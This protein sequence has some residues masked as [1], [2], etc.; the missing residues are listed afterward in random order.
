MAK[1][2]KNNNVCKYCGELITGSWYDYMNHIQRCKHNPKYNEIN[3]L[4]NKNIS[5][6]LSKKYRGNII[7]KTTKCEKCG[8]KF[9][10]NCHEI[11]HKNEVKRF[12]SNHCAAAYASSFNHKSTKTKLTYCSNCG[13]ELYV[14]VYRGNSSKNLCD[15][16]KENK[17]KNKIQKYHN[18]VKKERKYSQYYKCGKKAIPKKYLKYNLDINKEENIKE[19]LY[20]S[21]RNKLYKKLNWN[22]RELVPFQCPICGDMHCT[23][24]ICKKWENIH[25]LQTLVKYFKFDTSTLGTK[26]ALDELNNIKSFLYHKYK[27]ESI[28]FELIS[29]DLHMIHHTMWNILVRFGIEENKQRGKGHNYKKGYHKTWYGGDVYLRSSYEFTYAYILDKKHIYYEVEK[30]KIKYFDTQL[31]LYRTYKPDFYL[32]AT[33]TIIEIKPRYEG[34]KSHFSM[35]NVKD[36]FCECEKLGYNCKLYCGPLCEEIDWKL[37]QIG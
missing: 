36:K 12:C 22:C 1:I 19:I 29:K 32:P 26:K 21:N 31:Q 3:S 6:S 20:I 28:P 8:K 33:N 4:R 9:S 17:L 15:E 37:T 23:N 27:E 13:K 18:K 30:L 10:Y 34:D 16:C 2:I 14:S 24:E 35:Q 11:Y 5:E 25:S 7:S